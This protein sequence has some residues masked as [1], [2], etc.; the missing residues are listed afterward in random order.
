MHETAKQLILYGI[1]TRKEI[2]IFT[3]K[4][5]SGKTLMSRSLILNL[6]RSRHEVGLVSNPSMPVNEF[7]GE[8]LFQLGLEP[9]GTKAGQLRRLNDQLLE[10]YHRGALEMCS[11]RTRSH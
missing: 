5:G 2:V 1:H 6:S 7:L 4:I 11:L 8:I 9:T 10:N 3:R